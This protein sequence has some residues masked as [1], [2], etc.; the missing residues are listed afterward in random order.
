MKEK[1][2]QKKKTHATIRLK[3]ICFFSLANCFYIVIKV[4]CNRT[5]CK[6]GHATVRF[7]VKLNLFSNM[8]SIKYNIFIYEFD[9]I[10]YLVCRLLNTIRLPPWSEMLI[11]IFGKYCKQEGW[12]I[13]YASFTAHL[14]TNCVY[15]FEIV[16]S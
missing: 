3:K 10:D 13:K 5:N 4:C 6:K 9:C 11:L 16:C 7:K 14:I 1:N 8:I 12:L 15:I 2:K